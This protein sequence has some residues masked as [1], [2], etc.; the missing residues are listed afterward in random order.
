[1]PAGSML[2][3]D[4]ARRGDLEPFRDGF[5]SFAARNRFRHKARKIAAVSARDKRFCPRV[6]VEEFLPRASFHYL[7][8]VALAPN[9]L[10]ESPKHVPPIK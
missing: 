4:F 10:V 7:R 9:K 3:S 8:P 5:S 1:M 2:P 6:S